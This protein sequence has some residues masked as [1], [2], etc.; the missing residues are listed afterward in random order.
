MRVA[1]VFL[2][3]MASAIVA[4]AAPAREAG[5]RTLSARWGDC[6]NGWQW[7]GV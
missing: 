4:I 2:A 3:L 5:N 7:C 1:N 6:P